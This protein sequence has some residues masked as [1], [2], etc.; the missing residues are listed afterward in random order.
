M[1]IQQ[2]DVLIGVIS[3]AGEPIY[4]EHEKYAGDYVVTPAPFLEQT[5]F[6]NNKLMEDNVVVLEIPYYEVSNISG[7]TVIIGD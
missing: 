5:L 1:D 7:K 6:T 2:D 4:T 3:I